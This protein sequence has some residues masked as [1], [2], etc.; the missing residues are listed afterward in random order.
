ML[1]EA[2]YLYHLLTTGQITLEDYMEQF[3][4]YTIYD[5]NMK[6]SELGDCSMVIEK[7]PEDMDGFTIG[8]MFEGK[9]SPVV[10]VFVPDTNFEVYKVNEYIYT[11]NTL[12]VYFKDCIPEGFKEGIHVGVKVGRDY[13][14]TVYDLSEQTLDF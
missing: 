1:T 11:E 10:K 9:A 12:I 5:K 3:Q 4:L 8:S 14:V 7:E 13:Y 2:D 6:V